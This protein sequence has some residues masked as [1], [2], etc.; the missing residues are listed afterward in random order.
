MVTSNSTSNAEAEW[1]ATSCSTTR[2][3][4]QIPNDWFGASELARGSERH[5]SRH[6]D[7]RDRNSI[8][9]NCWH[10]FNYNSGKRGDHDT[11]ALTRQA[12]D[13]RSDLC[14]MESFGYILMKHKKHQT[15]SKM[16]WNSFLGKLW[17]I[18]K[19]V[20][21]T[22]QWGESYVMGGRTGVHASN[23]YAIRE[24]RVWNKPG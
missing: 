11:S 12:P 4:H 20:V 16:I 2:P 19:T 17:T 3:L 8:H 1:N 5:A 9:C 24:F 21:K 6:A 13:S 7:S 23:E 15:W 22:S 18:R 10:V 14:S